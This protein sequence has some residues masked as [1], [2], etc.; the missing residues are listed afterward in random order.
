LLLVKPYNHMFLQNTSFFFLFL[1][2]LS[3]KK[4]I[5][6]IGMLDQYAQDSYKNNQES[7][8]SLFS[9]KGINI[10][11]HTFWSSANNVRTL[12]TEHKLI[13][14]FSL[15]INHYISVALYK[16]F[17]A[18]I[19]NDSGKHS[20]HSRGMAT[21]SSPTSFSARN[22]NGVRETR[23]LKSLWGSL[24]DGHMYVS[25]FLYNASHFYFSWRNNYWSLFLFLKI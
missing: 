24:E 3:W 25:V 15:Y 13:F 22:N 20:W 4:N 18:P 6:V 2:L 17:V 1:F 9:I 12:L 11:L 14:L 5:Y 21:C 19:W 16:N 23:P 7:Q 10:F 8:L